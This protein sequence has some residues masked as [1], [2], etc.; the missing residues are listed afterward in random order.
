M[1]F[2]F[3]LKGIINIILDPVKEWK[4]IDSEYRSVRFIRNSFFIPLTLL[5]SVSAFAGSLV[6]TNSELSP[7]YSILVS[8]KSF[9]LLYF[10]MYSTAFILTEISYPLDLGRDFNISFKITVYSITPFLLCQIL[11]RLFESL[12]FVN[13]IALYGLYIFWTGAEKLLS[14]PQYKKMPMLIATTITMVGLYIGLNFIL[15]MVVDRVYYA[16][17][18]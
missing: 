18:V 12:L 9:C 5:V 7:V 16:F 17:F 14:P 15:N 6:F 8:I 1:N 11:S 13:I 2:K 3:F 4:S 10:T